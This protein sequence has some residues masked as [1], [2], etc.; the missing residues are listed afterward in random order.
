MGNIGLWFAR[1]IAV[2][3]VLGGVELFKNGQDGFGSVLFVFAVDLL[4]GAHISR[5][6]Q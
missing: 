4:F 1:L 6:S 3:L 2:L 5:I